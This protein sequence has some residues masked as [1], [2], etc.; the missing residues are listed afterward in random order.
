MVNPNCPIAIIKDNLPHKPGPCRLIFFDIVA[1]STRLT[2]STIIEN[3]DCPTRLSCNNTLP[4]T[5]SVTALPTTGS[6]LIPAIPGPTAL[7]NH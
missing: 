7:N 5:I 6:S 4:T 3:Y 1:T 2:S